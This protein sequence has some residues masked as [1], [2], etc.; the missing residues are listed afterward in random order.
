M[1]KILYLFLLVGMLVKCSCDGDQNIS[2]APKAAPESVEEVKVPKVLTQA[3]INSYE[4]ISSSIIHPSKIVLPDAC[5]LVSPE[6]IA[7][8]FPEADPGYIEVKDGNPDGLPGNKDFRSCFFKWEGAGVPNSG[9]LIQV[10][11]N[12]MPDHVNEW[13]SL[14]INA[15]LETGETLYEG[16]PPV[17]YLPLEGFG[18]QGCYNTEAGKYFWRLGQNYV[19]S[20]AYNLGLSG[21]KQLSTAKKL[22]AEIMKNFAP[23]EM[24]R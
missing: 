16:Q 18:D 14:N 10:Y 3:D 2:Q 7:S 1:R 23:H 22:G 12:P 6:F 8:I 11:K 13:P 17:K 4:S 19:L 9:I 20:I 21:N 24:K 15:K 5:T